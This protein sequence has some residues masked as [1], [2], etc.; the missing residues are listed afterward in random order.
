MSTCEVVIEKLTKFPDAIAAKGVDIMRE[1][2]PVGRTGGLKESVTSEVNG[3]TVRVFPTAFY[4]KY[5]QNGRGE[6]RPNSRRRLR[7]KK[8]GR[9]K[10]GK[11]FLRWIEYSGSQTSIHVPGGSGVVF[12]HSSRATRPNHVK[13]RTRDRLEAYIDD[14]WAS[15]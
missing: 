13:E 6:V 1:E 2:V 7:D 15:L 12:A 11:P 9:F 8:T 14:I 3:D 5:V 4:A 10:K